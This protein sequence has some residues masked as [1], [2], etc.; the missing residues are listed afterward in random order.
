MECFRNFIGILGC[1]VPAPESGRYINSLP[2]IPLEFFNAIVNSQQGTYPVAWDDIQTRAMPKMA[3]AVNS[4]FK[5]RYQIKTITESF[6]LGKKI[7]LVTAQTVAANEQRG[8]SIET[9]YPA[10]AWLTNSAL[11]MISVQEL[12][13]Y[14]K[15]VPADPVILKVFDL[16]TDAVLKTISV[17]VAD[18]VV[19]W[20]RVPVN[21]LFD[22]SKIAC[23]YNA[24]QVNSAQQAISPL[25]QN[26]F[27]NFINGW[28][29]SSCSDCGQGNS[30]I[31]GFKSAADLS[32][33]VFGSS[34]FGL[35]G[36]FSIVCKYD[37]LICAN[38]MVFSEAWINL[39]GAE[40]MTQALFDKSE[41]NKW[42]L[43]KKG[44]Q[45]LR[46]Y[47]QVQFEAELSNAIDGID[48]NLS[49]MCIQCNEPVQ[50]VE[51]LP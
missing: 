41:V 9:E 15:A 37:S 24:T 6:D 4:E 14:L 42:T 40:A 49:D 10:V 46:D 17:P 30:V 20:N 45:E 8:F 5:K 50:Y 22:A 1:N 11:R 2:G 13:I 39:L 38:K 28:I 51:M 21:S 36:I 44:I 33:Q 26:N 19:G 23:T 16:D 43:D 25:L 3:S 31:R 35:S 7:D 27:S 12:H 48:L 18:L 29:N 47:Y 34:T 32:S